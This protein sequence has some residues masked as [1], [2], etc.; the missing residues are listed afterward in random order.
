M[1]AFLLKLNIDLVLLA[2]HQNT[3]YVY[4]FRAK[5]TIWHYAFICHLQHV[6]AVIHFNL[7]TVKVGLHL[8]IVF[9]VCCCKIHLMM[10]KTAETCSRLQLNSKYSTHCAC[11]ESKY[12]HWLANTAGWLSRKKS[13]YKFYI[14]FTYNQQG[15][16]ITRDVQTT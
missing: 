11:S 16:N 6:L 14:T 3:I 10:A 4:I 12:R 7:L 2:R 15:W 9:H 1:Y 8:G 13:E 5:M